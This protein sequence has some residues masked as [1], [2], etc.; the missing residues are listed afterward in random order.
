MEIEGKC[1]KS[2]EHVNIPPQTT[3][4]GIFLSLELYF[5]GE[6]HNHEFADWIQ[7]D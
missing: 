2:Y 5:R 1:A 3:Q 6:K 7:L 4:G